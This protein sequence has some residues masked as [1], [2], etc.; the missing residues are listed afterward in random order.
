M[1][2]S[3]QRG[4]AIAELV[5]VLPILLF[6]LLSL[7]FS[8][9]LI[10]C[11]L[12]LLEAT[13]W[14]GWE[15]T[16]YGREGGREFKPSRAPSQRDSSIETIM[17]SLF[18]TGATLFAEYPDDL[19]AGEYIEED[20]ALPTIQEIPFGLWKE[21]P[22]WEGSPGVVEDILRSVQELGLSA[23]GTT[24]FRAEGNP[25]EMEYMLPLPFANLTNHLDP[26]PKF[27][28]QTTL[29]PDPWK[30]FSLPQIQQVLADTW[31]QGVDGGEELLKTLDEITVDHPGINI[32]AVP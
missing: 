26:P 23:S 17:N 3:P 18:S 8:V 31:Y 20:F 30:S 32:D 1:T 21:L 19:F 27:E 15:R 10:N 14:G 29:V 5:I 4:Q 22:V 24:T 25:L 11:K 16:V 28:A 6:L 13:R 2:P 7:P 12:R 9:Q